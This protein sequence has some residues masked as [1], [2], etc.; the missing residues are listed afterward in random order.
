MGTLVAKI[1]KIVGVDVMML[2]STIYIASNVDNA[3]KEEVLVLV[4][5]LVTAL[6]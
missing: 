5:V 1:V 2:A 3:N 6:M 4:L